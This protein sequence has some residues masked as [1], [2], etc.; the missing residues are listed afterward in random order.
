MEFEVSVAQGGVDEDVE[1]D[2]NAQILRDMENMVRFVRVASTCVLM[3]VRVH[4]CVLGSVTSTDKPR[5]KSCIVRVRQ[6]YCFC[7]STRH[8]HGIRQYILVVSV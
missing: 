8:S 4:G 3:Q 2:V 1:D 5:T 7:S 6:G